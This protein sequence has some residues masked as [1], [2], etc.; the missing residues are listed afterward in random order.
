MAKRTFKRTEIEAYGKVN[1]SLDIRGTDVR[2]Y[3]ILETI[4]QTIPVSDNVVITSAV[5]GG[6]PPKNVEL[7]RKLSVTLTTDLR[8]LP[9]DGKN[10]AM[11]AAEAMIRKYPRILGAHEDICINIR[12]GIPVGGGLGGSSADCAAVIKG[13]NTHFELGLSEA[14]MME[15]GA[16]LG[17]DVPFMIAGGTALVKGTGE[18]VEKLPAPEGIA[19]LL[20]TPDFGMDTWEVYRKYDNIDIDDSFR[21]DT[22]AL[23]KALEAGDRAAFVSGLKNV[24]EVPAFM[25]SKKLSQL[26]ERLTKLGARNV[27][28]SG[29]GSSFACIFDKESEAKA[30]AGVLMNEGL[31]CVTFRI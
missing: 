17:S 26:K 10:T 28:M 29:S 24:L 14:E 16:E 23:V 30:S 13:F 20:C 31:G 4:M 9:V 22:Q 6:T 11:R 12:K 19:V 27:L 8:T 1:F 2:R 15:I 3:H 7:P 21:P 18:I 25:I 5:K